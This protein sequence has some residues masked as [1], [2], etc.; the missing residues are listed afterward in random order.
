MERSSGK[1]FAVILV[2]LILVLAGVGLVT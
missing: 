1:V 2:C